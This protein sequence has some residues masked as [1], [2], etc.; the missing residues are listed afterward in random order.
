MI[1]LFYP[2][3]SETKLVQEFANFISKTWQ[4]ILLFK[5]ASQKSPDAKIFIWVLVITLIIVVVASKCQNVC[6]SALHKVISC[7]FII[8]TEEESSDQ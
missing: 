5:T 8:L 7:I 1:S 2:I 4:H 6:S 3:L